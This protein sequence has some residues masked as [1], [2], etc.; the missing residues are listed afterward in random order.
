MKTVPR[1]SWKNEILSFEGILYHRIQ[2]CKRRASKSTNIRFKYLWT[3]QE[4]AYRMAWASVWYGEYV[5]ELED[6]TA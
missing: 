2:Y 4:R 5:S 3:Y 1:H 6:V